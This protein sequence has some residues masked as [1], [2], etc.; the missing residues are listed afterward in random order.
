MT[1]FSFVGPDLARKILEFLK[2]AVPKATRV[3]VLITGEPD[4]PLVR[5][6]WGE[7]EQ[8]AQ[9]LHVTL[10][11]FQVLGKVKQ[12]DE[13]LSALAARRP[14]ALVILNDPLFF[15]HRERILATADRLRLPTMFQS[16]EYTAAGALLAYFPSYSD[17]G[18]RAA[19]YVDLIL[20]GT[21][22]GDLPIE[23][24]TKFELVINLTTAKAIGFTVP[25]LLLAR[26]DEVIE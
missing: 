16:K 14:D 18:K 2:L 9:I 24:P 7:L 20:R 21:K 17:Q 1:G 4:Q 19:R 6:V 10:H 11:R 26:A 12:L 15:L 5:A 22:A 13:A 3:A 23:Q 25:P 8:A